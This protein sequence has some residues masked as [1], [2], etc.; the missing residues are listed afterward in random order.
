MN[1]GEGVARRRRELGLTAGELADQAGLPP[2]YL[3]LLERNA[4]IV[5]VETLTKLARALH[6]SG[7][8]LLGDDTARRA[9]PLPL[10]ELSEAECRQLIS[11]GGIG[12][13]IAGTAAIPVNFALYRDDVVFRTSADGRLAGLAGR[14]VGFEV[15]SIDMERHRGWSV[16][17]TGLAVAVT[18]PAVRG[19]IVQLVHPWVGEDRRFC[20]RIETAGISGQMV[21]HGQRRDQGP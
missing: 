12:R 13:V 11:P 7:P 19:K 3:D 5:G 8:E 21:S 4:A 16:L 18:H 1:L 15:E 2:A 20:V 9:W 14:E 17:V 10:I 6:T